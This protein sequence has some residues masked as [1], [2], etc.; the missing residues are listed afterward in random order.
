VNPPAEGAGETGLEGAAAAVAVSEYAVEP[1]ELADPTI[2]FPSDLG[3][4]MGVLDV[5][6]IGAEAQGEGGS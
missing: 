1:A 5:M 6:G 4:E 2:P 3:A